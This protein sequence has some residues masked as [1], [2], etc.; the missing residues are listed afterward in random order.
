MANTFNCSSS[1]FTGEDA[2]A[3]GRAMRPLGRMGQFAACVCDSGYSG[4]SDYINMNAYEGVT[5][6]NMNDAIL[7]SYGTCFWCSQQSTENSVE[8]LREASLSHE[9]QKSASS[10]Y[11]YFLSLGGVA[12][13]FTLSLIK[14]IAGRSSL[15]ELTRSPPFFFGSRVLLLLHGILHG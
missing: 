14:L 4:N 12:F 1:L 11:L 3:T 7:K 15:S 9:A 8:F 10:N 2:R 13:A 5:D 6:C